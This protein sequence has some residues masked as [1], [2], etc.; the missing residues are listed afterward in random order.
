MRDFERKRRTK[1]ILE[2]PLVLILIAVLLVFLAKGTWNL[3]QKSKGSESDLN[4]AKERLSRLEERKDKLAGAINSLRTETG[5]EGEI[6][7]RLQMAREGEKEIVIVDDESATKK[8]ES[9]S[10]SGFL[11]KIW[12]FFTIR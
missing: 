5:M 6:R 4:L 10:K 3:Y 1:K 11:Q 12:D 8:V 2:S 9:E 7:D